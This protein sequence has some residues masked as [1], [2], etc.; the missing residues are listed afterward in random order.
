MPPESGFLDGMLQAALMLGWA[1]L[2]WPV[3]WLLA[4]TPGALHE[5]FADS[6]RLAREGERLLSAG[7]VTLLVAAITA[8]SA[9]L[10]A[11]PIGAALG[12]IAFPG[13]S[14]LTFCVLLCAAIPIYVTT[15]AWVETLGLAWLTATPLRKILAA[16]LIMGGAWGPLGALLVAAALRAVP[17]ESEEAGL[18]ETTPFLT[19]MTVTLPLTSWGIGGA[20]LLAAV[21]AM[22]E[23]T[24]TS[25]L[26]TTTYGEIVLRGFQQTG[27]H[28]LPLVRALP[29]IV[30]VGGGCALLAPL[31]RRMA[32][33]PVRAG[34]GRLRALRAGGILRWV[35]PL[36]G[37]GGLVLALGWPLANLGREALRYETGR[38]R[39]A[40]ISGTAAP[41]A[42]SAISGNDGQNARDGNRLLGARDAMDAAFPPISTRPPGDA[43][44]FLRRVWRLAGWSGGLSALGATLAVGLA[45]WPA[46]WL[47]LARGR[48]RLRL[49]VWAG[50]V[51]LLALPG[52]LIGVA[53][54][55]AW[56]LAGLAVVY[57][58]PI[59]VVLGYAIR[60]APLAM[61]ALWAGARGIPRETVEAARVE[62][63]GGA[64][65]LGGVVL[66]EM[67]LAVGA[68][69]L[70]A[71]LVSLGELGMTLLVVPPGLPLFS[72]HFAAQI[73][74]GVYPELARTAFLPVA[75]AA[76]P[77][78]AGFLLFRCA[79]AGTR[80]A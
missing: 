79:R 2:L 54:I 60:T 75:L 1:T 29:Q 42:S 72:V 77:T 31:I 38:L 48:R 40:V 10:L 17:S 30:L 15:T 36:A 25:A 43:G 46:V 9:V 16:G 55:R 59:I 68:A 51:L 22:G 69:W 44:R 34:S 37:V 33:I 19:A 74:F 20:A 47:A 49:A 5:T 50:V 78:A 8:A 70:I 41:D 53:L 35:V 66:P 6:A 64:A 67:P 58:T 13:R 12:R 65:L 39:P 4:Q 26:W 24:V 18:L 21:L 56:R 52:P 57:E 63:A 73:H 71:F 11:I 28:R 45:V 80:G 62:G 3:L 61:V 14:V 23:T 32:S 7:G 27:A 76:A